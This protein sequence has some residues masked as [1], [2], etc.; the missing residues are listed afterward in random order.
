MVGNEALLEAIRV[1]TD[2]I[3]DAIRTLSEVNL[4]N[5]NEPIR[6]CSSS[7]NSTMISPKPTSRNN[8]DSKIGITKE[9]DVSRPRTSSAFEQQR[10][11]SGT[12]IYFDIAN[13][14]SDILYTS[15]SAP[16]YTDDYYIKRINSWGLGNYSV[17]RTSNAVVMTPMC[18]EKQS[19]RVQNTN[20]VR[21]ILFSAYRHKDRAMQFISGFTK[22]V[23]EGTYYKD[24]SG[25]K[26]PP[27][28]DP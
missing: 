27:L 3:I 14:R 28:E 1:N 23:K 8:L 6:H 19:Y 26:S 11:L 7:L 10:R 25:D 17:A 5:G 20:E 16:N 13:N 15:K 24:K 18:G 22:V 12:G 21:D 4:H 2:K 9:R